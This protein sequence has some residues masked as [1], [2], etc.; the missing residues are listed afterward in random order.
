MTPTPVQACAVP[1]DSAI[2]RLLP[3]AFFH[4][5]WQ[6]AVDHPERTAIEHLMTTLAATPRWVDV[7]MRL[8]NRVVVCF[9]LKNLGDLGLRPT[10]GQQPLSQHPGDRVGIF[11]LRSRSDDEV[12]VEDDDKHLHVV[13]SV[14]RLPADATQPA[15]IVLTTVVHLHNLLGR[16]YMLPV[17]PMH[18]LIAPAVLA[19]VNA[20]PP[21]HQARH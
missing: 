17:A 13:L 20:P 9:G 10:H 14:R 2:A 8:R 18:R 6:V 3:G 7:A 5:A 4:D 21:G 1:A 16:L 12:L 15:R 11:T 19:R